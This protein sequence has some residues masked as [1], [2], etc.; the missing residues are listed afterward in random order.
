MIIHQKQK[1]IR[2][3][4]VGGDGLYG[5][6]IKFRASIASMGPTY[7]LDIHSRD[8]VYLQEPQISV[9][10]KTAKKGRKPVLPKASTARIIKRQVDCK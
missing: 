4:W 9:P 5:H 6:D 2:F 3:N 8:G 10:E 7:M 1:G